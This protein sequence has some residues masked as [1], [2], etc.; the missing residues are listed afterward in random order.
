MKVFISFSTQDRTTAA[1]LYRDLRSAGAEA[2]Q[3]GESETVGA[4]GWPQIAA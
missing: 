2:F 4:P 1:S 3:F